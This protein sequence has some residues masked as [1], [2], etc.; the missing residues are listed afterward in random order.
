MNVKSLSISRSALIDRV[1]K[2]FE[3]SEAYSVDTPMVA[4]LQLRR[5]EKD[6]PTPSHMDEWAERT[7]YRSLVGSLIY[8]ARGTRHCILR[9]PA[10]VLFGL[11]PSGT[12]GGCDTSSALSEGDTRLATCS[13]W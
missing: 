2:Q 4:G 5:L 6:I 3:Q 13:R 8:I 10:G 1:V 11:L 9:E 7:P 12:L